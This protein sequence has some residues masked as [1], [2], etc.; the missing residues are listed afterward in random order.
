MTG[1]I[2]AVTFD[3]GGTLIEPWPS[4]GAVYAAV[5]AEHGFLNLRPEILNRQFAAAWR[6]KKHFDHSQTAWR[7]LVDAA[8]AGLLPSA[9][10]FP[11]LYERFGR[12]SAWKIFDDVVPCLERLKQRGLKIGIISNWDERLRP[13]LQEL[14]LASWFDRIV[15][16]C[17][18]GCHKPSRLIFE[19]AAELLAVPAGSM[20]HVGDNAEEESDGACSAGMRALLINRYGQHRQ[21]AITS[22]QELLAD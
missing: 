19:R 18:L 17:E 2:H 11:A 22:L 10:F 6:S 8:F 4:V 12:A 15:I 14:D 13:L 21:N 16:S 1:P 9:T 5:A 7:K 3:V 20:L